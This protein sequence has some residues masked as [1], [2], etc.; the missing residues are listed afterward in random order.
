MEDLLTACVAKQPLRLTHQ[1][2]AYATVLVGIPCLPPWAHLQT[3]NPLCKFRYSGSCMNP[4][5]N[6]QAVLVVPHPLHMV[7]VALD[8]LLTR[9]WR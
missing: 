8:E 2:Q 7:W 6:V 9:S 4:L 3:S 1:Q 5:F